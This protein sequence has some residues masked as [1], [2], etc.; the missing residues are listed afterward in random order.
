M[1]L[2]LPDPDLHNQSEDKEVV[3]SIKNVSK[4]FCRD[5]KRSLLYGVQDIAG[6]VFGSQRQDVQLRKGEFWALKDVNLEL[7]RGEALGLVGANGAG[8]TTLLRIISG[9]ITP[10]HGSVEVK[11]RVAPLIALGAGFNPI[12]TGRENVYVNMSILGLSKQEI[13]ARFDE[14]V[15][16]AEIGEAIDSPVQSYSSGMAARLGFACAIHTEPDILLID[17]VLAVG[18]IKFRSKCYRKLSLL[19]KKG[20]GFVMVSHDA[21]SIIA[22]CN[23]AIL[24]S[25]GEIL[26][27][28]NVAD[29]MQKYDEM[30]Y[31]VKDKTIENSLFLPKKDKSDST[32]VDITY[33]CFKDINSNVL[34]YPLSG[35]PTVFCIGINSHKETNIHLTILVN[36][37]FR[38]NERLLNISTVKDKQFFRI[39]EGEYEIKLEMPYLCLAQGNFTMKLSISQDSLYLYD[40]VEDFEFNVKN[41]HT[42][43]IDCA[44]YQP[45]NWKLSP[46][47]I[48]SS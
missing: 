20:V 7:R 23:N 40:A 11:G 36:D 34:E 10:D 22:T 19:R 14:V 47:A 38:N 21:N 24:L 30:L 26:E 2:D 3:L 25:K 5:L 28:G 18:D 4:R 32:G 6:E 12:L 43:M 8:K 41:A 27:S 31:S 46:N 44:F 17:E 13:E 1:I 9:L 45:K 29:V 37:K 33:L 16:F 39:S 48:S 15:E 42:N 35:T